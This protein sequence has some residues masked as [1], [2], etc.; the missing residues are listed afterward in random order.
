MKP[1]ETGGGDWTR[2]RKEMGQHVQAVERSA[3]SPRA[4]TCAPSGKSL[5]HSETWRDHRW[6]GFSPQRNPF[7]Q[8]QGALDP[9]LELNPAG[10]RVWFRVRKVKRGPEGSPEGSPEVW[11][12]RGSPVLSPAAL[13]PGNCTTLSR[14]G[15]AGSAGSHESRDSLVTRWPLKKLQSPEERHR[16]W[17]NPSRTQIP[18][19]EIRELADVQACT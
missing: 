15:G 2:A 1:G 10:A 4:P 8:L 12:C 18:W 3:A 13:S 14:K 9:G 6:K 11:E 7:Q 16:G 5:S 19:R 17:K